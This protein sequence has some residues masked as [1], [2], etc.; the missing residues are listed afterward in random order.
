MSGG[1]PLPATE[2]AFFEPR[3]GFDLGNVRI[4]AG[5]RADEAARAI[6]ARAFTRGSDIGFAAGEFAPGT[7]HGRRLL[8]HELTHVV[9]QA[10]GGTASSS[11]GLVQRACEPAAL[12]S[13]AGC[14]GLSG[15]LAGP[16]FLFRVGCDT[17][18][19]DTGPTEERRLRSQ[20]A[21]IPAG[22]TVDLHG[23]A[24]EEGTA[25]FN[26]DLS[27][28]RALAAQAVLAS[29]MSALGKTVTFRIFKH[30]GVPGPRPDRRAVVLTYV[31]ATPTPPMPSG[32][33]V[34]PCSP[35]PKLLLSRPG[36]CSGGDDFAFGDH[37]TL[38]WGDATKVAFA[39]ASLNFALLNNMRA[40]LGVLGGS[41]GLR[42]VS[43]FASGGGATLTHGASSPIGSTALTAGS[44]L[45]MRSATET[46]LHGQ[47]TGMASGSTLDCNALTLPSSAVPPL[48]FAF[49][50]AV[51]L[52]AIIGGTQGIQV[53]LDSFSV[54]PGTRHYTMSLRYV[55]CD[56]FGVDTSD[57]YSP[58]LIS[59][60]VLQHERTGFVPFMNVIDLTVPNSGTF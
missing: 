1:S 51:M 56:D 2:R 39:R 21:L 43:H 10:K 30:G 13:V 46:F 36:G 19:T 15:D 7:S 59:F 25:A 23:F 9:Q 33:T 17:L 5:T 35:L 26:D 22:I 47:L 20:A 24:S 8:A 38:G 45:A 34:I 41:E 37:P 11:N 60:W 52:K 42:M 4:H 27:C 16:A 54:V 31:A 18:R 49:S 32:L 14:T 57:L 28:A 40:E 12:G 55:I 53:Y 48:A 44:F 29:E 50:D 6:N 3:F 58:A